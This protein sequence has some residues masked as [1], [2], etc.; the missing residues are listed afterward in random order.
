MAKLKF[1]PFEDRKERTIVKTH[2][3]APTEVRAYTEVHTSSREYYMTDHEWTLFKAQ[4]DTAGVDYD[5]MNN[6]VIVITK[7]QENKK[8]DK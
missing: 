8:K 2:V 6:S 3:Y 7:I 4:L 1:M 5:V